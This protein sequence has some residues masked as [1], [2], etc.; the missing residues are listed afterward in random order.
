MQGLEE[1]CEGRLEMRAGM[2]KNKSMFRCVAMIMLAMVLI[3]RGS[4]ISRAQADKKET[5]DTAQVGANMNAL[6]DW[7]CTKG[8]VADLQSLL[9]EV[10]SGNA[11][12]GNVQSFVLGLCG[13]D[14]QIDYTCYVK[15]LDAAIQVKLEEKSATTPEEI[16][17]ALGVTSLQ[18]II[19]VLNAIGDTTAGCRELKDRMLPIAVDYTIGQKGLMSFIYG[20]LMLSGGGY[21]S[22]VFTF[23]EIIEKLVAVQLADGGFA[24]T[25]DESDVDITAMAVQ[26]IA[27]FLHNDVTKVSDSCEEAA[28]QMLSRATEYLHDAQLAGGDYGTA[29]GA[30]AGCLESTVQV[31]LAMEALERYGFC[32]AYRVNCESLYN[33]M[34]LYV[35]DGGGF[36]H[37]LGGKVNEMASSQAM[38]GLASL[39]RGMYGAGF[40]FD[41]TEPNPITIEQTEVG[42]TEKGQ[43][44]VEQ[45][46]SAKDTKSSF[47]Y[48]WI[49]SIAIATITLTMMVICKKRG[50]LNRQRMLGIAIVCAI[51]IAVT[52]LFKIETKSSYR[53]GGKQQADKENGLH[54]TLEIRCD[55]IVDAKVKSGIDIPQDGIILPEKDYY[56]TTDTTVFDVLDMAAREYDIQLE[57]TGDALGGSLVYVQGIAYLY[58]YDYGDLSGWMYQV[59]GK[60]PQVGCGEY[61]LSDGERIVWVYTTN[62]GKDVGDDGVY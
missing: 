7:Q 39:Y 29:A 54:V 42:Q 1:Y 16:S 4:V 36:A 53:A 21:D 61:T 20:L 11:L 14:Y 23:E 59:D 18:K 13:A 62:L 34:M 6:M 55:T 19:M 58:E 46:V 25:G 30:D 48:R 17:E 51:L 45:T 2:R 60:F 32:E 27:L 10:Y 47:D 8:E 9:D 41:Y 26:A 35:T 57:Y 24:L 56:V 44:E 52:W 49:L 43:T 22:N 12:S 5:I 33:G 31:M 28:M 38:Y 50:K 15:D 3:V 37:A 40:I